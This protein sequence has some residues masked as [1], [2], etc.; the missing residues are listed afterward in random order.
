MSFGTSHKMY[1]SQS[2]ID[3]HFWMF[4]TTHSRFQWIPFI[5][6]IVPLH[7]KPLIIK[8]NSLE[9]NILQHKGKKLRYIRSGYSKMS[10]IQCIHG[11][12]EGVLL[13][14][15][16]KVLVLVY[17]HGK[18]TKWL[19]SRVYMFLKV[20]MPIGWVSPFCCMHEMKQDNMKWGV[21]WN[22]EA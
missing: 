2:K 21:G 5:N 22:G 20:R 10:F 15:W 13:Y 8:W 3:T 6:L 12:M 19:Y 4:L 7:R 9:G 1:Q 17:T 16:I 18:R 14:L 11:R